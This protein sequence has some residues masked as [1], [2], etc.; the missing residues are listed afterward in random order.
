MTIPVKIRTLHSS[1]LCLKIPSI[2]SVA[3]ALE[4]C[5]HARC[6]TSFKTFKVSYEVS[7]YKLAAT[8]F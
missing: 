2:A 1:E 4:L 7:S 5:A 3:H 6:K 8:A